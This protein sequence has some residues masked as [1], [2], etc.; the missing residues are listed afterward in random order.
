MENKCLCAS[1]RLGSHVS[2]L[3]LCLDL[4]RYLGVPLGVPL[5]QLHYGW[6]LLPANLRYFL[7]LFGRIHL[8]CV[9]PM[10]SCR[11]VH[12]LHRRTHVLLVCI[13]PSHLGILLQQT[14]Y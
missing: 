8:Q 14:A 11:W 10:V 6:T 4:L 7:H 5:R 12:T 2:D 3:P 9:V 13:D 1:L